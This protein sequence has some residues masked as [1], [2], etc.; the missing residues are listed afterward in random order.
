MTFVFSTW[1]QNLSSQFFDLDIENPQG[2]G[3][4]AKIE[5]SLQA[6]RLLHAWLGELKTDSC[7]KEELWRYKSS[8]TL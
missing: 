7:R 6:G 2:R 1:N 8:N 3:T 5:L 4:L